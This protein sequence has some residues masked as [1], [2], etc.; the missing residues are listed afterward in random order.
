M[1]KEEKLQLEENKRKERMRV[2]RMMEERWEMVA[3]VT[4]YLSIYQ[5]R[6][7]VEN[8]REKEKGKEEEKNIPDGWTVWR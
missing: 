4:S 5:E 8:G 6:W 7:E 1:K 3:W 2:K